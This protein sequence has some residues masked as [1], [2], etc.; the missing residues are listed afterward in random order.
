MVQQVLKDRHRCQVIFRRSART[1]H[2]GE[3]LL[4]DQSNNL[5]KKNLKADAR[6]QE[7][8]PDTDFQNKRYTVLIQL[9]THREHVNLSYSYR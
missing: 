1:S 2:G 7:F 9:Y 3:K 4:D 5:Y 6:K 8:K